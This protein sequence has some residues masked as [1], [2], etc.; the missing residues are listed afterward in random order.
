MLSCLIKAINEYLHQ[1]D[2]DNQL[3]QADWQK[4]VGIKDILKVC[5]IL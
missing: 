2:Q 1:Y 5:I 4:L 3:T